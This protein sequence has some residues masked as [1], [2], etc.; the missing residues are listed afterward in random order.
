MRGWVWYRPLMIDWT[1]IYS[2]QADRETDPTVGIYN[3]IVSDFQRHYA[4]GLELCGLSQRILMH[5]P[6]DELRLACHAV[7]PN[8][9]LRNTAAWVYSQLGVQQNGNVI[10]IYPIRRISGDR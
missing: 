7:V 1:D 9:E 8:A 3:D 6:F 2:H 4:Y 5:R 10:S